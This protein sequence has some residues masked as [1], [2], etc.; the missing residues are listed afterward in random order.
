MTWTRESVRERIL[1]DFRDFHFTWRGF[2][3]WSGIA[4]ALA[5]INLLAAIKPIR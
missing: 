1:S 3:K 4:A 2:F 5:F